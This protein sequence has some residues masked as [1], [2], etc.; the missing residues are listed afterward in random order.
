[1]REYSEKIKT[2]ISQNVK[3]RTTKEL[4][5]IVNAKYG[6]EFTESKMRS[7]KKN[8]NL[9]S[10]IR[11]GVPAGRATKRYPDE[12][13]KFIKK[14]YKGVGHKEMSSLLNKTF[15][16][17]YTQSQI[18]SFYGN[19][20]L[21]SGLT[22]RFYKGHT[23]ANKG[24]KGYHTPGSEKGWFKKGNIPVGHKPIGS[25]RI[26]NKDGYT[27]VKTAEPNV[28]ELKHRIIWEKENGPVPEGH[29]ITF[30]DGDKSNISLDNLALITMAE[31]LHLTRAG[32]R[33]SNPEFTRT[34]ILVAKVKLAG[35]KL[36]KRSTARAQVNENL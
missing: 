28:W 21:N 24:M 26:D 2:F 22:G 36:K 1:M 20:K 15:G 23:P 9:K 11:C 19:H 30:L 4:V 14:N 12:I 16:T 32:L 18:K 6:T 8:H 17:N 3:G 31:S 29:V 33:S 34:G 5:E 27:L 13:F 25:E 35:N 7:Y 10:G